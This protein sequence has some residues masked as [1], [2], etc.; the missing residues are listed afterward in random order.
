M[1][2]RDS[3]LVREHFTS[4]P[5]CT[6]CGKPFFGYKEVEKRCVCDISGFGKERPVIVDDNGN[7]LRDAVEGKDFSLTKP[8]EKL[9][10]GDGLYTED[11]CREIFVNSNVDADCGMEYMDGLQ[12]SVN[13]VAHWHGKEVLRFINR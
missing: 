13:K 1:E 10:D 5:F 9:I 3:Q 12:V 6:L 7:I 8:I 4:I 2:E 11:E